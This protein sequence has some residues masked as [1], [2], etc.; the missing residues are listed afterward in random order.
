MAVLA[1]LAAAARE[2]EELLAV[3]PDL[4]RWTVDEANRRMKQF[5]R[6][7]RQMAR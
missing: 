2:A 3:E 7:A 1:V 5:M 4:D 6:V